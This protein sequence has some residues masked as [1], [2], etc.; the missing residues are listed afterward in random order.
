[1]FLFFPNCDWLLGLF[2]PIALYGG[3]GGGGGESGFPFY[4]EEAHHN[5]IKGHP[6]SGGHDVMTNSM[7]D[8]M[9]VAHGAGG[10]PY[11]DE[12]AFDP[13][14]AFTPTATSPLGKMAAQFTASKTIL[15]ALD[16]TTDWGSYVT[17]AVAKYDSYSNIDF[18]DNL[19]TA[20]AGLL[21]AVESAL[22]SSSITDMVTAFENNKK[23]RFL[24][25][26]GMWS[27][28]MAD[29]NAVHTS[30]FIM[31]LAIQQ[32]EFSN[33]VDQYERELKANT[34]TI[35]IKDAIDAHVKAEVLRVNNKDGLIS[36]GPEVMSNLL[37]LKTQ[38]QTQLVQLKGEVE[39]LTMVAMKEEKD[40]Q[41]E[42][43]VDE[44]TWDMEVYLYGGNLMAS[45]SGAS[46]GRKNTQMS[47][48]QTALGGAMG[49]A[50]IGAAFG[51]IGAGIG[52]VA[53]GLLGWAFG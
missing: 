25:D 53:G 29:I 13:D 23:V 36:Q 35:I 28:G 17:A 46:V 15:D 51:P 41:V 18:L 11:E 38:A 45:I 39:R 21:T 2:K 12:T 20:I 22:S 1:M 34:Y 48:G 9:E 31:G 49:G 4:L 40:R 30:S 42:L 43:E 19:A 24:R 37:Q 33:S 5:W 32:I 52:F 8:L 26:Q 6:D 16:A 27:A 50:S 14:A 7:V 47:K 44:A 3:G 10:N